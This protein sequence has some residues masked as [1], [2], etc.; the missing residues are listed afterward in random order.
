MMVCAGALSPGTACFSSQAE[1]AT[2]EHLR[3]RIMQ[4]ARDG[5]GSPSAA[6][7]DNVSAPDC[8]EPRPSIVATRFHE[9]CANY[10]G[11]AL[12]AQFAVQVSQTLTPVNCIFLARGLLSF[13]SCQSSLEKQLQVIHLGISAQ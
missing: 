2:G 12:P 1:Y 5:G 3:Q 8:T 9:R 10:P 13:V 4:L 7:A 11:R 6:A